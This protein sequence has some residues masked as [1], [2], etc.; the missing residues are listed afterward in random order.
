MMKKDEDKLEIINAQADPSF[1]AQV[2]RLLELTI[3]GRWL[4]VGLLWLTIGSLSLWALRG[5][6]ALLQ[7]HFTWVAV[8]YG[9]A[10]NRLPAM[11]LALCVGM[12]VAVMIWQSRNMLIGIPPIEKRRLEQQVF[13]IRQQGK[14]HPLWN[15]VCQT[16]KKGD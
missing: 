11:G 14:S 13:R 3:Y 7:Q 1:A 15:L 2:E 16:K 6:I 5:E 8:K 12:T 4:F 9:L 10:Y